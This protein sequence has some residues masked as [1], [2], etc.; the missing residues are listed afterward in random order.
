MGKS[1]VTDTVLIT[2][3]QVPGSVIR[4]SEEGLY[5]VFVFCNTEAIAS[6]ASLRRI[7]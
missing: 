5:P 2:S 3:H 4:A 1:A 6:S 7:A